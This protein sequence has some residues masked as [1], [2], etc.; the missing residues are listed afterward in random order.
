MS[1]Q[2][3]TLLLAASVAMIAAIATGIAVIGSPAAQRERAFDE[4]RVSDLVS[5]VR[6]L[7]LYRNRHK[8]LPTNLAMLAQEPGLRPRAK[9]PQTNTDYE[10]RV[11]DTTGLELCAAFTQPTG[12]QRAFF[13]ES[14]R[15]R[16]GAGRQCFQRKLK[17]DADG[18]NATFE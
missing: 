17:G 18:T 7:T 2:A 14:D 5:L 12:E 13:P 16:H 8:A 1:T 15:W 10:Y 4:R 3:K 11:I 6:D 9:D